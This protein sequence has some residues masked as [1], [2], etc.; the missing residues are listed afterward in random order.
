M[1]KQH[2]T[3]IGA[4]IIFLT[5]IFILFAVQFN[6]PENN[7]IDD[8]N[9]NETIKQNVTINM[10]LDKYDYYPGETLEATITISNNKNEDI[11]SFLRFE[12]I[13]DDLRTM[14][15]GDTSLHLSDQEETIPAN[16]NITI[17]KQFTIPYNVSL[18]NAHSVDI[19]FEKEKSRLSFDI[20][21]LFD[22]NMSVPSS[23]MNHTNA[24]ASIKI[25]NNQS[26]A[27]ENITITLESSYNIEVQ[28]ASQKIDILTSESNE[29]IS[30]TIH[31]TEPDLGTVTFDI[32][33][34][35]AGNIYFTKNFW[36]S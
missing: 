26:F 23:M 29:T 24:T 22:V 36:V 20:A 21:S 35:N 27:L 33:S 19:T 31:S 34:T 11:T 2:I 18:N 9:T 14:M 6:E 13:S 32:S 25:I 30:W 1:K 17:V 12:V 10:Q 4:I 16:D 28:N 15:Y 5:L 8:G 7:I 3:I